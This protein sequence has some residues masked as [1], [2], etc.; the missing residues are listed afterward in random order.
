MKLILPKDVTGSKLRPNWLP[1]DIHL[2]ELEI[3]ATVVSAF[4][5]NVFTSAVFGKVKKFYLKNMQPLSWEDEIRKTIFTGLNSL[6]DLSITN[7]A[8]KIF[9]NGW[10]DMI[11][12]TLTSLV[13]TGNGDESPLFIEKLTGGTARILTNVDYVKIQ[14][15]L[16]KLV[17]HISFTA[18]PNVRELDLSDCS[19]TVIGELSFAKIGSKL[20][21]LNLERNRLTI[22]PPDIFSSFNFN[23]VASSPT[24]IA[25]QSD[26]VIRLSENLWECNCSMTHLKDLLIA[27]LNF[28]GEIL[29]SSPEKI[30]DYPIREAT[31]CPDPITTTSTT[32]ITTVPI[33]NGNDNEK[34]CPSYTNGGN[35]KIRISVQPKMQRI[36]L[37]LNGTSD[38][39]LVMLEKYLEDL[40]LVWFKSEKFTNDYE[41]QHNSNAS[42]CFANLSAPIRIND[43]EADTSYT[44]CLLNISQLTVSPFD[45]ISYYNHGNEEKLIAVWLYESSKPLTISLI[46]I[47]CI[48]NIIIGVLIGSIFLKFN[49]YEAFSYRL[50]CQCW[51]DTQ[52]DAASRP[53]F[54]GDYG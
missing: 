13:L 43:L 22:L 33:D 28:D 53:Y 30:I 19:I 32:E 18:I 15:N 8:L 36:Q 39:V 12:G 23:S 37:K 16:T 54:F 35:Q 10:L 42:D 40:V 2:R 17:T 46:V 45:C 34:E 50:A 44:F 11:N 47:A 31:F 4:E 3:D 26:L 20:E 6:E 25:L 41:Y 48:A 27:N 49:G 1:A 24:D 29:C 21:I 9:D 14:Y 51:N 7:S 38:G 52:Q 5:D